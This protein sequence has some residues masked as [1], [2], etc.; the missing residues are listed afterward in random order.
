MGEQNVEGLGQEALRSFTRAI[1]DDLDYPTPQ[2]D[3][4]YGFLSDTSYIDG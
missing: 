3:S 4:T 1:L 2:R